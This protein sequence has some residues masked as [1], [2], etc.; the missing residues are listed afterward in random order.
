MF[1]YDPKDGILTEQD[2]FIKLNMN[3]ISIIY[4]PTLV[5]LFLKHFKRMN[6]I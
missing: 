3:D 1:I 2:A 4:Q 5:F 6:T